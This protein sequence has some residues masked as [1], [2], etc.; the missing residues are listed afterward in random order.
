MIRPFDLRDI[1]LVRQLEKQGLVLDSRMAL[2]EEHRPLQ[3]ALLAYLI[4]GRG[5]PTFVA[6]LRQSGGAVSALGQVRI[7]P[8]SPHARLVTL[9]AQPEGHEL[10]IWPQI[11]DALTAQA[12]RSGVHAVLAE[13]QDSGPHFEALRQA[14]FV[15]YTRQEIWRL[16]APLPQPG[17]ERLRPEQPDDQWHIQQLVTNTVPRLIQQIEPAEQTGLGLVWMDDGDDPS[18]ALMAYARVHRGSRG[19]W[20][21]LYIHPQAEEAALSIVEQAAAHCAPTPEKPLYCCVRRY[22]EWL[23]RPLAELGFESLGSQAVMVRHTTARIAQSERPFIPVREKVLEATTP[24][25][26]SQVKR[27][28][29]DG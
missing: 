4:A 13:T 12:G 25:V 8:D 20:M 7:C 5:A 28:M 9:A 23:N 19:I 10:L 16:A 3:D 6:R 27:E 22:Q 26:Q 18:A 24:I 2:T 14:D 21:Q 17:E 29:G 1:P 15:V 11:L